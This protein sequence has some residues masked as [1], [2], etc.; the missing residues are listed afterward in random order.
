MRIFSV[1][2]V[3]LALSAL[4]GPFDA[5]VPMGRTGK[6]PTAYTPAPRHFDYVQGSRHGYMPPKK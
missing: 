1:C 6:S 5:A 3:S 4:A 2:L